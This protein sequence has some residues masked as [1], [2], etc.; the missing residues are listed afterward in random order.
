MPSYHGNAKKNPKDYHLYE[1]KDKK[2]N[3]TFKFGISGEPIENKDGLSKR[4]REQINWANLIAGWIRFFGI[5][6]IQKIMGNEKARKEEDKVLEDYYD[7]NDRY[8]PGNRD[9][10]RSLKDD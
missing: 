4:V 5:I 9:R 2:T 10:K 3:D 8:P 6:L 7:N 1:I